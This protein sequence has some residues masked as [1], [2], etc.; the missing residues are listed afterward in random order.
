MPEC[1]LC[2]H[3]IETLASESSEPSFANRCPSCGAQLVATIRG[4]SGIMVF[5]SALT[6]LLRIITLPFSPR[7]NPL[8]TSALPLALESVLVRALWRTGIVH[9]KPATTPQE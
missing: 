7:A 1:P 8:K 5:L 3:R 9:L 2:L 6:I 4:R